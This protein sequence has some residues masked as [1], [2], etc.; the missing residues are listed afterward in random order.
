MTCENSRVDSL[1]LFI[2]YKRQS[3]KSLAIF[4][5]VKRQTYSVFDKRLRFYLIALVNR[6]I[7]QK[8]ICARVKKNL[9]LERGTFWVVKISLRAP[10]P[11]TLTDM[12]MVMA[13]DQRKISY[14]LV[15]TYLAIIILR[16]F[17][18]KFPRACKCIFTYLN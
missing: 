5:F 14:Q 4:L 18:H 15:I 1:T 17:I 16:K 9:M 12:T 8:T 10:K 2:E 3:T 13:K 11:Q 7:R 6:E